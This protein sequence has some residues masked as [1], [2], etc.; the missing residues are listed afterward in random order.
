MICIYVY[1]V[2]ADLFEAVKHSRY[3]YCCLWELFATTLGEYQPPILLSTVG[4]GLFIPVSESWD[5]GC[6]WECCNLEF[7]STM[8]QW[9]ESMAFNFRSHFFLLGFPSGSMELLRSSWCSLCPEKF[10]ERSAKQ[11][12]EKKRMKKKSR[13]ERETKWRRYVWWGGCD[14]GTYIIVN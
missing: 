1:V 9:L 4:N 13:G 2:Q 5:Q 6:L 8:N 14:G 11:K 3:G 10:I 7:G 12:A